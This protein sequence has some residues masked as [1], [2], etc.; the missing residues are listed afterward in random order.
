[1]ILFYEGG[2]LILLMVEMEMIFLMV[3]MEVTP[4]YLVHHQIK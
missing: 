1:M 3:E 2:I 4:Q